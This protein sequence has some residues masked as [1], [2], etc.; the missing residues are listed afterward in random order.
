MVLAVGVKPTEGYKLEKIFHI[1]RD[2]DL[3]NILSLL[4]RTRFDCFGLGIV[5]GE[6]GLALM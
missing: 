2:T 1:M 5:L 4:I 6:T 3:K